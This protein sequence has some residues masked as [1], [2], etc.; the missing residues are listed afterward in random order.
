MTVA[1]RGEGVVTWDIFWKQA[2]RIYWL[3][4]PWKQKKGVK[5]ISKVTNL[6]NLKEEFPLTDMSK[7]RVK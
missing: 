6:S 7:I 2:N 4:V 5:D 1:G 3:H